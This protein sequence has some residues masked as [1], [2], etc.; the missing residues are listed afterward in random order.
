MTTTMKELLS[1]PRFSDLKIINSKACLNRI[2]ESAEIT[3]TPDVALYI[4][5]KVFILT[6]AMSFQ[7]NQ[8]DLIAFID[9]LISVNAAGLGIKVNRFLKEI[10]PNVIAYADLKSFP[11]IST[12]ST[13]PLGSL[14]HQLMNYLWDT[15]QEEISYALD[16]Q[17]TFSDL[18]INGENIELFIS[19]LGKM[20]QT[21]ILLLD[22][23]FDTI[24]ASK[25]FNNKTN[26]VSY[27][28]E[29]IRVA[30][31]SIQAENVS[32][33]IRS[34]DNKDIHIA[35]Y[36]IRIYTYFPHYLVVLH[37]ENTPYP[38]SSFA[39]EQAALV[40]SFT[41]FKNL[42]VEESKLAVQNDI[43][44][45]LILDKNIIDQS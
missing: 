2:V 34:T 8:K 18:L 26:P 36:P 15:K 31:Q 16:I 13:F 28:I 43:L 38:I 21:P 40:L 7:N 29:Q 17:K 22:P 32:L 20:L 24:T 4:P 30:Y 14:L 33:I 12:P 1:I 10:H 25:Y 45:N 42:K 44:R 6:T 35:L 19:E 9:S 27:Y 41:I 11:L 3:E 39:I 5:K 23:L 37:P